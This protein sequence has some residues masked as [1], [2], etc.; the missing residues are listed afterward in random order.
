[1]KIRAECNSNLS[2]G[3]FN[4]QSMCNK[5]SGI[6]ELL[7]DQHVDVCCITE[8]WFSTKEDARFAEIHELGFDIINVPRKGRGGGIAF[9]FNIEKVK[10]V[11]NKV[12]GFKSFEVAECVI[13]CTNTIIR[14]CT[15]YRTTQVKSKLK[16]SETKVNVFMEEFDRYLDSLVEKSG[17]PILCGDFNFHVE[18]GDDFYAKKFISLYES[19]GFS[20]LVNEPTHYCGS[21][22][23]LVLTL[24]STIDLVPVKNLAV[25]SDTGTTS[26]HYLIKFDLPVQVL[27][28]KVESKFLVKE[29]REFSKMDI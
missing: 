2:V 13:K 19:K 10:P 6:L 20:Q 16:Y 23:D 7:I 3:C 29:V 8:T 12:V 28:H 4:A 15:I 17:F 22:L 14:L 26:D 1:M 27:A 9:V 5:V 25:Q 11:G 24:N 21:T 18:N